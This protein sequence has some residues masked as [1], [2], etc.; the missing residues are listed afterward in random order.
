MGLRVCCFDVDDNALESTR[1][2][3]ADATFN[4]RKDSKFVRQVRQLTGRRGCHAAAVFSDA[5]AAYATA[6]RVLN[7]DGL[8][9]VVGMPDNPLKFPAFAISTNLFR[10]KGAS[11][12]TAAEMKKAVDFTA[13][14]NIIPDIEFRNLDEMPQMWWEMANGKAR[15]KLGVSFVSSKSKL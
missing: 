2:N 8:L 5:D 1:H 9:M 15:R 13:K 12:G 6:Q 3:G 10:V 7:F 4:T 11:N 14:H